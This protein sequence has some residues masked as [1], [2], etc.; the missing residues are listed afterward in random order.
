MA[1]NSQPE[2]PGRNL[3]RLGLAAIL[4][5]AALLRVPFLSSIPNGFYSD[6]ASTG[7]DAYSIL[8]TGRDQYGEFLPLLTRSF[9]DYVEASYRYVAIPFIAV[10]GLNE[11]S[12]RLPSAVAGIL[13]IGALYW[14][15]R[16]CFNTQTALIASLLLAIS[17]WH[18]QFSR[19]AVRAILLPL[20]FCLGLALFVKGLRR[21]KFIYLS[22]ATFSICLYTYS[23]ARVFL[24]LFLLGLCLIFRTDLWKIRKAALMSGLLFLAAFV[25]LFTSWITPEGMARARLTLISDP[26]K[27]ALN[28]LSYFSPGFLFLTGDPNLRHSP[29]GVGQLHYFELITVALGSGFCLSEGGGRIRSGGSGSFC[30]RFRQRSRHQNTLCALSWAVPCLPYC[31]VLA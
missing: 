7:Y 2:E 28:S 30:I 9:G 26:G 14:L 31:P 18:I 20:L 19:C 25:F 8:Q 12:T 4:L 29:R 21:S 17:P 6:E 27:I 1:V 3:Q 24:P 16:I 5:L 15:V 23:S 22:A 10:F 13:T 11:F